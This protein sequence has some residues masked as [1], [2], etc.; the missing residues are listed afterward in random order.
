LNHKNFKYFF[1][2]DLFWKKVGRFDKKLGRLGKSGVLV[3]G[4]FDLLPPVA[5]MFIN[6]SR[7]NEH[8]L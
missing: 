3:L 6:G 2:N 5:D 8:S 1:Y 4:R 7:R